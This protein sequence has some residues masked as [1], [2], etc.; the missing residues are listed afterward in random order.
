VIAAAAAAANGVSGSGRAV[1]AAGAPPNG[2]V[3]DPV[4]LCE[5]LEWSSTRVK[6]A[7]QRL[8]EPSGVVLQRLFEYEGSNI[9]LVVGPYVEPPSSLC[10]YAG[11]LCA[12]LCQ[13]NSL[14][15]DKALS[16]LLV[17]LV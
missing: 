3:R 17:L 13:Y 9:A 15:N 12:W 11:H 6:L 2:S 4:L 5:L 8:F 1:A 7:L 10:W 16:V 14:H